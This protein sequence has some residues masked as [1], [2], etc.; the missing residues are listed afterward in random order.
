M[1]KP[2]RGNIQ[3]VSSHHT[4]FICQIQV[5]VHM[6][7]PWGWL[8]SAVNPSPTITT[9]GIIQSLLLLCTSVWNCLLDM[10]PA[11][12]MSIPKPSVLVKNPWN[13]QYM[14]QGENERGWGY[15][16]PLTKKL[17]PGRRAS[18]FT[19]RRWNLMEQDPQ[20]P[21]GPGWWVLKS[22]S[23]EDQKA[24]E[25]DAD[26]TRWDSDISGG[27]TG[28]WAQVLKLAVISSK[29]LAYLGKAG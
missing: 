1:Y 16:E 7:V 26:G 25:M 2:G 15:L 6:S 10:I 4:K 20:C 29:T 3:Q 11:R 27:Y 14:P 22:C 24:R 9:T 28:A 5:Q 23:A 17:A 18:L 8:C 13:S 19:V 12:A 21:R